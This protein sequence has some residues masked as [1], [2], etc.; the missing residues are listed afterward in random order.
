MLCGLT[1]K[2]TSFFSSEHDGFIRCVSGMKQDGSF[3][4]EFETPLLSEA[5]QKVMLSHG[6][7]GPV[8]KF[9]RVRNFY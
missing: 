2:N 4:L 8:A 1:H 9:W 7:S 3:R 5:L 6:K